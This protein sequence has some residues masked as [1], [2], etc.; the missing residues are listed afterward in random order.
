MKKINKQLSYAPAEF[1]ISYCGWASPAMREMH[2]IF[3]QQLALLCYDEAKSI[4]ELS[5]A[6]Q[7]PQ[8]YIKDA[9]DSFCNVKMMKNIDGKY[10]TMFPMLSL[11]KNYEASSLC[12]KIFAKHEIP[13][14]INDLLFSLKDKITGFDFYG[15]SFGLSYL[16]WFLYTVIDNCMMTEFR[17]YYSDKTDEVIMGIND[18]RTNN[19]DFSLLASYYYADEKLEDYDD[20]EYAAQTST[21]YNHYGDIEYNNVFDFS[22]FP[23]SFEESHIGM[24]TSGMGR[25]N[26]V[27]SDNIAF[28]LMLVK[29]IKRKFTEDEKKWLEDFEKHG[30]VVKTAE[31]YKPMIPVFTDEVFRELN[32]ILTRA[33]IP[34]VKEIAEAADKTIEEILLPE[35]RGVKERIDQLYTFWLCSSLSPKAQLYWY[36]MNVE[37][38]EIPKD[39]KASAA[40]L[41]IVTP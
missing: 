11:K 13:K 29:G 25:H 21:Y 39:Y 18:W 14:K 31:G 4:E 10:L 38:L 8:E 23:C 27:T 19:Y 5:E 35:M 3:R 34:I 2:G 7:T 36:G 28:Y 15:N 1:S 32:K 33:V 12:Y 9:V 30:V 17:S 20:Y 40:G 41:Y 37:G 24:G 26:Y 6:L 16:N 22:P